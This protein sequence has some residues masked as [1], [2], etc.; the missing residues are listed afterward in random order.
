VPVVRAS[1]HQQEPVLEPEPVQAEG[2][3]PGLAA[4]RGAAPQLEAP[5][6]ERAAQLE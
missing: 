2:Q 4:A 6:T 5:Q 3:A 1:P